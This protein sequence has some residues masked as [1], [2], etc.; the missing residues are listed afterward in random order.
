MAKSTIVVLR[1][2]ISCKKEFYEF[3]TKKAAKDFTKYIDKINS[4]SSIFGQQWEYL[5]QIS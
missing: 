1:H 3:P 2:I 5:I 4:E